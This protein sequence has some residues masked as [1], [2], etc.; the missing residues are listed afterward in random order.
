MPKIMLGAN[1][2]KENRG[3][4]TISRAK[5]ARGMQF[6]SFVN[7]YSKP[8]IGAACTNGNPRRD[9]HKIQSNSHKY[10]TKG[11]TKRITLLKHC[12]CISCA[13]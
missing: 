9:R 10:Q 3:M 1:S 5:L 12:F 6:F 11:P 13:S 7:L 8:Y 4:S 2:K